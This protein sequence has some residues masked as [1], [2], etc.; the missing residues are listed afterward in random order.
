MKATSPSSPGYIPTKCFQ[1]GRAFPIAGTG[2]KGPEKAAPEPVPLASVPLAL[3]P[4]F[5]P[6]WVRWCL[7]R[8]ER[9]PKLFP[10]SPHLW[11]FSPV[12]IRRCLTKAEFCP[13]LF[14]HSGHANGFSPVCV[15]R[16]FTLSAPQVTLF[17][18]STHFRLRFPHSTPR[19]CRSLPSHARRRLAP[20]PQS[21]WTRLCRSKWELW[22]KLFPQSPQL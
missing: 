2:P 5:S 22:E 18:H 8:L 4:G 13:K 16:S 20:A 12:C 15:P 19:E 9:T 6:K 1:V 10:H 21:E 14:P 11:G 17:P 7:M 3:S